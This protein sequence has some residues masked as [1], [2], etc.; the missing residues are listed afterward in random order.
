MDKEMMIITLLKKAGFAVLFLTSPLILYPK[1]LACPA[2]STCIN[3]YID[4][5]TASVAEI[6]TLFCSW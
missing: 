6:C 3:S 5:Q 1:E 4:A 2:L